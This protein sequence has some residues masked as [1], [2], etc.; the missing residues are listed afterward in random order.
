V[1]SSAS[2]V[3]GCDAAAEPGLRALSSFRGGVGACSAASGSDGAVESPPSG[4]RGSNESSP[5]SRRVA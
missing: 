1:A 3:K 5:T 2:A 4:P